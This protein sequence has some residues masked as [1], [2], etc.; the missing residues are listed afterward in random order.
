MSARGTFSSSHSFWFSQ[1]F[2][3]F[4]KK[5]CK[6]GYWIMFLLYIFDTFTSSQSVSHIFKFRCCK[7]QLKLQIY[8]IIWVHCVHCLLYHNFFRFLNSLYLEFRARKKGSSMVF[9]CVQSIWKRVF[10]VLAEIAHRWENR[11][12][13][14][15]YH[16]SYWMYSSCWNPAIHRKSKIIEPTNRPTNQWVNSFNNHIYQFN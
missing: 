8:I 5:N 2:Y 14:S 7:S 1:F 12:K 10:S 9:R 15:H 6:N 16:R 4:T 3:F 13:I 11:M